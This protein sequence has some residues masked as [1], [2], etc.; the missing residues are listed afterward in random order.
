MTKAV[1]PIFLKPKGSTDLIRLGHDFDGGYLV[2]RSDVMSSDCLLGL[3]INDD[4]TFEKDFVNLKD[5][6]LTA[7]D[8]SVNSWYFCKKMLKSSLVFFFP[9]FYKHAYR[10]FDYHRFFRGK[11][12]HIQSF[13]GIDN[14]PK[15][16]SMRNVF[17]TALSSD[18]KKIFLKIDV[19]GSEYLILDDLIKKAHVTTGLIIEFHDCDKHL[20]EIEKFVELYPLHLVHLHANNFGGISNSGLP[21]VLEITF[22]PTAP[23]KKEV[24]LPHPL[25]MPCYKRGAEITFTFA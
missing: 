24:N 22:S 12:K 11:R 18:K 19:E 21:R 16:I 20:V 13:V 8:A 25:D 1:A 9:I 4:W 17:L 5:V 7:F 10:F 14:P 3:G 2:E 23:A 6:D 15:H